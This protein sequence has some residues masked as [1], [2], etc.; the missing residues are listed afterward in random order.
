MSLNVKVL[1]V[2]IGALRMMI[3]LREYFDLSII[4]FMYHL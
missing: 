2:E 3:L 4:Y 1:A